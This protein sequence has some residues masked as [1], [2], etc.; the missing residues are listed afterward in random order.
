VKNEAG[1]SVKV[2]MPATA[3]LKREKAATAVDK[4]TGK[5]LNVARLGMTPWEFKG[6]GG[7]PGEEYWVL[8]A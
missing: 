5:R 6:L 8:G 7:K 3:Y 4:K 1:E 2:V